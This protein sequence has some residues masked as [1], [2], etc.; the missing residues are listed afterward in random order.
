MIIL[1][2]YEELLQII[3]KIAKFLILKNGQRA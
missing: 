3:K 1:L 2:M